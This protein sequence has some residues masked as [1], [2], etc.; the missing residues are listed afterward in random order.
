MVAPI[1]KVKVN[2][3]QRAPWITPELHQTQR[4]VRIIYRCFRRNKRRKDLKAYRAA[5]D[6]LRNPI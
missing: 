4:A 5:R 6:L 1:T 3:S 2:S